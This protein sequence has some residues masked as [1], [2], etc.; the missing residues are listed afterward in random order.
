MIRH[1]NSKLPAGVPDRSDSKCADSASL[2]RQP[3]Q[4]TT[5]L[6]I[7]V[8]VIEVVS[9][10][11]SH[12]PKHPWS[13]ELSLQIERLFISKGIR[14]LGHFQATFMGAILD[15]KCETGI[16]ECLIGFSGEINECI[17]QFFERL[18]LDHV[19]RIGIH[20]EPVLKF[21]EG[22]P[23][24]LQTQLTKL[25]TETFELVSSAEPSSITLSPMVQASYPNPL[26]A[27]AV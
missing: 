5:E 4:S 2:R 14:S 3:K 18:Q 10:D 6:P 7:G 26:A 21:R 11:G 13:K 19:A 8:I 24:P 16:L 9:Q 22:M 23:T 20:C 25:F 1:Q 12:L 27:S 15:Q 17:L